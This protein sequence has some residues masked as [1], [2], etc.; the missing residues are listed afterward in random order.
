MSGSERLVV[1]AVI[2]PGV[3]LFVAWATADL[4][5]DPNGSGLLFYPTLLI[6]P[7][8]FAFGV[9]RILWAS[10]RIAGAH[11]AIAVV[12][13]AVAYGVLAYYFNGG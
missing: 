4:T 1:G 6:V 10:N 8:I 7:M 9:T 5:I 11:A 3:G 13:T 2:A 12:A